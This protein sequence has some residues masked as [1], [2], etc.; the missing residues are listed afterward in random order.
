MDLQHRYVTVNGIR[1]HCVEAGAGETVLF[2]HWY[3]ALFRQRPSR[4]AP[5]AMIET[6]TLFI[7]G[8]NDRALGKELTYGT[9]QY[10]RNLQTEYLP[11]ISHWV[12]QE[13]SGEVNRLLATHLAATASRA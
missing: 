13:A 8:E 10:V 11:G 12:Q 2:T 5:V 7:W 4:G 6:P 9:D 1:M 3:R